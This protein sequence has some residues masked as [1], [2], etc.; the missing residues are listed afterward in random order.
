ML[1]AI[2]VLSVVQAIFLAELIR[3]RLSLR[4]GID[5]SIVASQARSSADAIIES[6]LKDWEIEEKQREDETE[7]KIL[8]LLEKRLKEQRFVQVQVKGKPN[9]IAPKKH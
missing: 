9:T 4:G 6:R 8:E 2:I 5:S 1:I 7:Q 3:I